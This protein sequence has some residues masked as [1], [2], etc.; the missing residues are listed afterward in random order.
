MP[1][2]RVT[3]HY[4]NEYFHIEAPDEDTARDLACEKGDPEIDLCDIED[5]DA[6]TL[7]PLERADTVGQPPSKF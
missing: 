7:D 2:F 1:L 5:I 4:A 3:V 6:Q